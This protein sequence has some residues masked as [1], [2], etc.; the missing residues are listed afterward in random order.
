MLST[1]A[2]FSDKANCFSQSERALYG[3]FIINI[4]SPELAS[5]HEVKVVLEIPKYLIILPCYSVTEQCSSLIQGLHP[6]AHR[7]LSQMWHT[8]DVGVV[9]HAFVSEIKRIFCGR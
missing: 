4:D 7:D 1:R 6:H 5:N 2:L 9:T 8:P 3:N